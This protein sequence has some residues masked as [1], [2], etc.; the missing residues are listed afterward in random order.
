MFEVLTYVANASILKSGRH[1]CTLYIPLLYIVITSL[2][3]LEITYSRVVKVNTGNYE[4]HDLTK[5]WPMINV[6]G[7]KD[8]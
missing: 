2:H 8:L 6:I 3:F 4:K 7:S 5:S 1:V